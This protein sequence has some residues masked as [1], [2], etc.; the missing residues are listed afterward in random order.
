MVRLASFLADSARPTYE[1]I[2]AYLADRLD[3]PVEFLAGVPW[4]ER[5]R[6]LDAGEIDL[7]FICGLPYTRKYDRPDRPIELLCAPVMAASRYG[8]RPIYF[9]DV[10][11]RREHPARAFSDLR[12]RS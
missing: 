8:G 9:T 1:R 3:G 2:A 10:V 5:H 7:A 12:G 6:R 11:V 4:E